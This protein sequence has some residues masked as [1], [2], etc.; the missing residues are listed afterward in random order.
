MAVKFLIGEELNGVEL[1]Q[2]AEYQAKFVDIFR[3]TSLANTLD[4][5][6]HAHPWYVPI[7]DEVVIVA[8]QQLNVVDGLEIHGQL[9]INGS[10]VV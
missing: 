2:Q 7:D 4:E 8:Y 6:I 5:M 10:L 3:N 9:T 1:G